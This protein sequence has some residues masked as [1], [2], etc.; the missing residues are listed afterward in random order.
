V[1]R[2]V[3]PLLLLCLALPGW[4]GAAT[5]K[6]AVD[7]PKDAVPGELLV[8]FEGG[9]SEEARANARASGNVSLK[10]RTRI[11]GLQLVKTKGN[12]SVSEA[13]ARLEADPRVRFAEPNSIVRP[14]ATPSD[15]LF[16][17]LWGLHNFGQPVNG[18]SSTADADIDAPE[19]WDI[20]TG[21]PS[22]VV[23]VADTGIAYE[24]PELSPRLWTNPGEIRGDGQDNDGNGHVDDVHGLDTIDHD[25]DPRDLG[26]HGTHV[27]GTIAAAGNDGTGITGVA[28]NA[29]IMPVRVLGTAGGTVE[30]LVDGFDYAGDMGADVVNASLSGGGTPQAVTDV[31]NAHPDVLFVVAASNDASNNDV[32][33]RYPCNGSSANLICVA[34]TDQNDGLASFSNYGATSVD[35]AAPGVNVNSSIPSELALFTDDFEAND[36]TTKW[37][38]SSWGRTSEYASTFTGGSFSMGDSPNANYPDNANSSVRTANA[39]DFENKQGCVIEYR[40]KLGTELGFDYL[41]VETS[42]DLATWTERAKWDGTFGFTGKTTN[43][44]SDGKPTYVRFR[45]TSDGSVDGPGAYVDNVRVRCAGTAYGGSHFAYLDGTSMATPHVAGAAAV[46]KSLRPT[47][48]VAQLRAALLDSGDPKAALAGKTVTGRRL[49]LRSALE[50]GG[51]A[52]TTGSATALTARGA[53]LNGTINPVGR[54]A[55]YKFEWGLTNALGQETS[56]TAAGSG[57]DAVPAGANLTGLAPDAEYRYR[58]VGLRDGTRYEG[59]LRT[60]RTNPLAPPGQVTGLSTAPLEAAVALDWT[61]TPNASG[62]EVYMREEGGP[63]PSSALASPS[64]SSHTATGL[65]RGGTYCFKVRATN[66]DGAGPDSAEQCETADGLPPGATT[67]LAAAGGIHYVNLDWDD[68]QGAD[69]YLVYRGNALGLSALPVAVVAASSFS[70]DLLPAGTHC[71]AIE[72]RNEWGTGAR[73]STECAA[74]LAAPVTGGGA[75]IGTSTSAHAPVFDFSSAGRTQ[76]ANTKG[77]F[78]WTFRTRPGARGTVS[79]ATAG[80]VR[81]SARRAL[82][83]GRKAFT[84]GPDGRARVKVKL[85]RKNLKVLRK[86]RRLRLSATVTVDGGTSAK[87]FTLKAPKR[88]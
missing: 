34:A 36:F 25:S 19:A 6:K 74:A 38:T 28:W 82:K 32:S 22:T 61:D 58:L 7:R 80:K 33:A 37:T 24:H 47:A 60:F 72:A 1:P 84:A 76:T 75:A 2:R 88:R 8:Q 45:L 29:R 48:T 50:H 35:M 64:A 85:G 26:R 16:G 11:R 18:A 46:L 10:R 15:A 4:A 59:P 63:Y 21:D 42:Q 87:T 40:L 44:E 62:Y 54:P 57:T 68:A 79:F 39:L 27:A 77:V 71:Y 31:V 55:S 41:R 65:E 53:T 51:P 86:R 17:T 78:T 14:E 49:N 30:S 12:E 81:T 69:E 5:P 52:V 43:L 56:E 66:G 70:D 20:E 83:L 3:V 23:A 9:V 67:G 73:S 13:I